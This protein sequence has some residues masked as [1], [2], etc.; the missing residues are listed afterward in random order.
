VFL[1]LTERLTNDQ[2]FA[3]GWRI[4]F[5]ASAAL[6]LVGLYVR[7]SCCKN[8]EW[9]VILYRG[10][11]EEKMLVERSKISCCG[12]FEFRVPYDDYYVLII[13][14]VGRGTNASCKPM[15]TLK[16]VGVVSLMIG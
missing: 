8:H 9:E 15:L 7:L 10:C 4:P 3:Y 1:L 11:K 5:L 12:C 13:C 2:F 14:P 16:N 6:V